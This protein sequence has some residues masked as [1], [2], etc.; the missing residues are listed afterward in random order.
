MKEKYESLAAGVLR[1]LAKA[2]G[3]PGISK[4]KKEELVEVMLKQDDIDAAKK[5]KEEADQTHQDDK[6]KNHKPQKE[7]KKKKG[8]KSEKNEKTDRAEKPEKT[9]K[10]EKPDQPGENAEGGAAK[11][12]KEEVNEASGILE[13]MSD[14]FG[15]IR[16]ENFCPEKRTC[17]WLRLRSESLT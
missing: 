15:F 8:E 12:N 6:N 1:D 16:C 7:N 17:M 2:R 9:E 10:S 14:G 11:E 4:L 5:A 13:V 3:I